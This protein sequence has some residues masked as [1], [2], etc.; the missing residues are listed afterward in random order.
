MRILA[1]I[2]SIMTPI[3]FIALIG[4]IR[5]F[6]T[7]A[8]ADCILADLSNH[9]GLPKPTGHYVM[10]I[11]PL[12]FKTTHYGAYIPESNDIVISVLSPVGIENTLLHEFAHYL[13]FSRDPDAEAHGRAFKAALTEVTNA[14]Y[15]GEQR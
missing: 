10:L 12:D 2:L 6:K 1:V 5:G 11:G 15:H 13:L 4:L 14:F 9:F 3:A 7:P 8:Q